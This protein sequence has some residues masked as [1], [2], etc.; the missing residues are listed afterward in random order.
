MRIQ[1]INILVPQ[2][3]LR[4][5][6]RYRRGMS[7]QFS[8]ASTELVVTG[9]PGGGPRAG[10]Q[11]GADQAEGL[12]CH[13][14]P[15]QHHHRRQHGL[16][17]ELLRKF[18]MFL[19]KVTFFLYS[20]IAHF[21]SVHEFY[22]CYELSICYFMSTSCSFLCSVH[23]MLILCSVHELVIIYALPMDCLFL[24]SSCAFLLWVASFF[25]SVHELLLFTFRPW[26]ADFHVPYQMPI[27]TVLSMTSWFVNLTF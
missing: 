16:R 11:H 5:P 3:W 20:S 4:R 7:F 1:G 12:Q 9:G 25:C 8:L 10:H 18:F 21:Y 6:V 26:V 2:H 23:E 27:F 19:L 14:Q 24:Q 13:H 17:D 15:Q 22:I